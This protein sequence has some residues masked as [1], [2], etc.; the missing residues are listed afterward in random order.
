M[1]VSTSLRMST[2]LSSVPFLLARSIKSRKTLRFSF[3][4]K[5]I[6]WMF[7]SSFFTRL[8]TGSNEFLIF[9]HFRQVFL[10]IYFFFPFTNHLFKSINCVITQHTHRNGV[11]TIT[12]KV[13]LCICFNIFFCSLP[14]LVKLYNQ[15]GKIVCPDK[16]LSITI[17]DILEN[18][19]ICTY[20]NH[21]IYLEAPVDWWRSLL[22]CFLT[23]GHF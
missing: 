16:N 5:L 17:S 6:N 19:K 21:A 22:N 3:N 8:I 10:E 23:C 15:S 11:C 9:C 7:F 1:K 4:I 14:F 2:S 12:C 18:K 13:K 20:I